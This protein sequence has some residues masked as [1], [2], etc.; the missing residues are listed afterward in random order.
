MFDPSGWIE[1]Q[2]VLMQHAQASAAMS[3]YGSAYMNKTPLRKG[4]SGLPEET[5][6]RRQS[7]HLRTGLGRALSKLG[8]IRFLRCCRMEVPASK[9]STLQPDSTSCWFPKHCDKTLRNI[10][11]FT[12][13]DPQL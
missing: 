3:V 5:I 10:L 1:G 8:A 7:S 9:F 11:F 6:M 13:T 4:L 12:D 2:R